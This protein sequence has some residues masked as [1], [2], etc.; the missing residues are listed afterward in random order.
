MFQNNLA[1][2]NELLKS[3]QVEL[4]N[5]DNLLLFRGKVLGM[6]IYIKDSYVN[7][8]ELFGYI[9]Q[10]CFKFGQTHQFFRDLLTCSQ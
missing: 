7:V 1:R 9:Y 3:H 6:Q 8:L 10:F 4:D 2:V 5:K